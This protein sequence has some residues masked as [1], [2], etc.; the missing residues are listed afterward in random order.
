MQLGTARIASHAPSRAAAQK[1]RPQQHAHPSH[2]RCVPVHG[3][4]I[5]A[6]RTDAAV[7]GNGEEVNINSLGL[8]DSGSGRS[9]PT[10]WHCASI[11]LVAA[12]ELLRTGIS[13]PPARKKTGARTHRNK[14]DGSPADAW[15]CKRV[16]VRMHIHAHKLAHSCMCLPA[17]ARKWAGKH[18]GGCC[19]Q[20]GR[21]EHLHTGR[22][23]L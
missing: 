8:E 17:H 20:S 9:R 22:Q 15:T 3:A 6:F 16:E 7:M 12:E 14:T 1:V 10:G 2:S 19:M 23:G 4:A 11:M 13:K 18:A 21:W 5:C